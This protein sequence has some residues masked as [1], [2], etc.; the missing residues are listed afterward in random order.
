MPATAPK[1][2]SFDVASVR[3]D[4]P[5]LQQSIYDDTPLVYLDNAATSQK[6]QV[7]I[8]RL[9]TYYEKENSNVHRGVHRLSQNAT[10]AFED[11]R[12]TLRQYINAPEADQV[13]F[14]QG[15]TESINIVASTF[16]RRL[17]EGDEIIITEMEHHANI[18]P[19]QMLRD[20]VG[21]RLK[22]VPISDDGVL[23]L[24][25]LDDAITDRTR[26]V[27]VVHISNALGTVNPVSEIVDMAHGHDVPV[28]V[29]GAQSVP[30]GPVD[31]QAMGADFF[32]FS[33]HKMCGPTG[34]GALYGRREMLENLPPYQGGGDMIDEVTF[35][36]TTYAGLPHKLEAGTPNIA[37]AI[38]LA[39]AARYMMD[40]DAEAMSRHEHDL[41]TYATEKVTAIDG[42]RVV[43]TAPNKTSVVSMAFDDLHPYDVGTILDRLGVA[44][45]TG[46]HC[47]QPLMQRLGLP[48]TLR[49]S[50]A[51]YNTRADADALAD[52][53]DTAATMLR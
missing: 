18:V 34:I 38:G 9:R 53:L 29:D 39:T 36:N 37:D 22:V 44:V 7:V 16:G 52:A 12:E 1:K 43:G 13:I 28:L 35:E 48:G 40:L 24:N 19:W 14:T 51:F 45:R 21:V 46:H 31:V 6:P 20:D 5:A 8:D 26:L 33:G 41:L 2:E 30:H 11:A 4:F 25:A 15:T 17:E 42:L 3:R 23:D 50:F 32:C 47:A 10:D 27:A 49:A